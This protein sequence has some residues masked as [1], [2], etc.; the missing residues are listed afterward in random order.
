M[1]APSCLPVSVSRMATAMEGEEN[2]KIAQSLVKQLTGGDLM[3]A[4]F[5]NKEFFDFTPELKLWMA[6]NHK[7]KVSGDDPA[8]WRRIHLI[9]FNEV[10][11][12]DEQDGDLPEKL[13]EEMPGILNWAVEGAIEWHQKGLQPPVEVLAATEGYRT[14][15][16]TFSRFCNEIIVKNP[17]ANTP[18]SDAY[19]AYHSWR[20]EEGG[21]D[22]SKSEM[23]TKM[24]SQ[25]YE[26]GRS[27]SE[28]YW[29]G[30]ELDVVNP[31]LAELNSMG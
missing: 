8:I 19:H 28:R 15:M 7:P 24:K 5:L 23:T 26:E 30:I 3:T 18:K 31:Y 25:G 22:F 13:R 11:P 17:E 29:K 1:T 9:P 20:E 27:K 21:D 12:P 4:R 2:Q 6:T 10:I 16:D 14:E